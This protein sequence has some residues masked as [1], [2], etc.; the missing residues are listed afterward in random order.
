MK[1]VVST[2]LCSPSTRN[3]NYSLI[4]IFYELDYLLLIDRFLWS[5]NISNETQINVILTSLYFSLLITPTPI[6]LHAFRLFF[7]KFFEIKG[8]IPINLTYNRFGKYCQS[9]QLNSK[10]NL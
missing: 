4:V 8:T 5:H 3:C 2:L 10:Q 1:N 9:F 6:L 7:L